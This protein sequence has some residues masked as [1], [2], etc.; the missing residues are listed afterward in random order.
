LRL[1]DDQHG[2]GQG[3]VDMGLPALAQDLGA[4]PAVVWM[5]FDAEEV[6]HLAI[7]VG[8]VGLWAADHANL[9]VTLGG[10]RCGQDAQDGGLAGAGSAG[11]EGEAAF[12]HEL[13]DPP[14]ERFQAGGDMQRRGRHGGSERIPF[15]AVQ[16]EH[17]VVHASS[18]SSLGR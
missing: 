18:P 12:A 9:H 3:F 16:R 14:A 10:K 6:A 11:D 1:V 5:E 17:L 8:D 13:L 2:P 7:E 15:E 4:T